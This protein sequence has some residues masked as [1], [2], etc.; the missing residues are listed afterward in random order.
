MRRPTIRHVATLEE[1]FQKLR[2]SESHKG[3][4][5]IVLSMEDQEALCALVKNQIFNTSTRCEQL[6]SFCLWITGEK[7]GRIK[8]GKEE[9]I[10]WEW[11]NKS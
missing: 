1:A 9:E 7:G 3:M 11:S 6:L 8:E 2:N 5:S 10:I 4:G